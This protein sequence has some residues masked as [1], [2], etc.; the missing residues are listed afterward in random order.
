MPPELQPM[1]YKSVIEINNSGPGRMKFWA[2]F[3]L[4]VSLFLYIGASLLLDLHPAFS[5]MRAFAEGALV[6][7]LADWF[8]VTALF[9]HPLGLPIPHTAI[10]PRRKNEIGLR[11]GV[12]IQKHF[13]RSSVIKAKL[14]DMQITERLLNWL[15]SEKGSKLAIQQS[16]SLVEWMLHSLEDEKIQQ[17]ISAHIVDRL[18]NVEIAPLLG[19]L[20]HVLTAN[21]KHRELYDKGVVTA[22][23]LF[24]EYKPQLMERIEQE[25]PWWARILRGV[26]YRKVVR[27]ISQML[28][29]MQTD[30]DHETRQKFDAMVTKFIDDL[31]N[32]P[33]VRQ[34]CEDLKNNLLQDPAVQNYLRELWLEIKPIL[35]RHCADP[36]SALRKATAEWIQTTTLALRKETEIMRRIERTFQI[37][38]SRSV[39]KYRHEVAHLITQEVERWDADTTSQLI[40]TQIGSDL[41]WIR[42]NGTIVGGLAG[43]L[44]YLASLGLATISV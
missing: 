37:V 24:E 4:I 43:L 12:F 34:K 6:G 10:I 9:A 17:F 18:R 44:I 30:P 5:Y 39:Q 15:A 1:P 16:A 28:F 23:N 31:H 11:L 7:G 33:E 19:D 2:T 41:Q 32:S 25:L 13:L 29:D 8:A 38:V 36:D 20:L 14:S 22:S 3:W 40:E 26:A 42:I 21:E 27:N 35:L